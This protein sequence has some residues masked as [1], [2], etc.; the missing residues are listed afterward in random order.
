MKVRG[1]VLCILL[2]VGLG[3][4]G[5]KAT[6]YE[7]AKQNESVLSQNEQQYLEKYWYGSWQ[8]YYSDTEEFDKQE[9]VID[10]DLYDGTRKYVIRALSVEDGIIEYELF[11]LDTEE[12]EGLWEDTV[13][14]DNGIETLYTVWKDEQ[15]G[16]Q[17]NGVLVRKIQE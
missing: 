8:K 17:S 11:D 16:G 6:E 3:G 9:H 10:E 12:S 2:C 15:F 7:S 5:K 1:L 14:V 13:S 4:C